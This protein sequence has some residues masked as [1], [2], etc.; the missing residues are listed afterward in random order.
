MHA[1]LYST[2][3]LVAELIISACIYYT[4]YRGYRHNKFPAKIAAFALIYE[5]VFNISYMV[6]RVSSQ[7]NAARVE[8]PLLIGLA[9][10]HGTLSLLMF[11]ALIVFFIF[12]WTRYRKGINYFQSHKILT[13]IFIFFWTFSIISGVLFYFVEYGF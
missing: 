1:P 9:I 12:A 6:S 7:A 5:S 3:T 13:T 10:V 2:I 8:S 11:L 4:L